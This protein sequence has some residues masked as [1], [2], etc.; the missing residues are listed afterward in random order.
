L[1]LPWG[2]S[3]DLYRHVGSAGADHIER[4]GRASRQ[5]DHALAN[6][7]TSII[8]PNDNGLSIAVDFRREVPRGDADENLDR[9][10]CNARPL[11]VFA[12][13]RRAK[14]YFDAFLIV[15]S[16]VGIN[17]FHELLDRGRQA[18]ISARTGQFAGGPISDWEGLKR[19]MES[20]AEQIYLLISMQ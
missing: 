5:V 15:P 14:G 13:A 19:S 16:D 11:A 7:G 12:G 1:F 17:F 20:V 2:S 9:L 18:S 3:Q 10:C 6:V 8:D 4:T